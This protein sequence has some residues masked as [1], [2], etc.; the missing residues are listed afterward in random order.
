MTSDQNHGSPH[1]APVL[2]VYKFKADTSDAEI[3][4]LLRRHR[5][6]L[7]RGRFTTERLPYVLRSF[8]DRSVF[9]E[10]F[11]WKTEADPARAHA[12]PLVRAM[13]DEFAA[14]C[15]TVG[16]ALKDLPEAERPFCQFEAFPMTYE[17][18][19]TPAKAA[20]KGRGKS[21]AKAKAKATSAAPLRKSAKPARS[22]KPVRGAK[23][24]K[25]AKV[26]KPSRR[27]RPVAKKKRR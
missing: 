5:A 20:A 9:V 27:A 12:D 2:A 16:M 10:V 26:A 11:D 18:T 8:A 17:A 6:A 22:A 23:A 4:D 21:A 7:V 14:K 25:A 3:H 1:P 19:K 15:E 13:W 24:A